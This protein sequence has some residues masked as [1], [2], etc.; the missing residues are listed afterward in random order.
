[1]SAPSSRVLW[2]CSRSLCYVRS[3]VFSSLIK[4]KGGSSAP[5]EPPL[6]ALGLPEGNSAM[7]DQRMR[8]LFHSSANLT[9]L[10]L[11][12]DQMSKTVP[13][14]TTVNT[15]IK[16]VSSELFS[17]H[18]IQIIG[19]KQ[20]SSCKKLNSHIMM[21]IITGCKSCKKIQLR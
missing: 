7:C 5:N 8:W 17:V 13:N 1:M 20:S 19:R 21:W 10:K 4:A 2:Y 9:Q 11:N 14:G 15:C 3:R 6:D 12:L 16:S 18:A